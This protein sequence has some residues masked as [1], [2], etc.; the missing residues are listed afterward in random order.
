MALALGGAHVAAVLIVGPAVLASATLLAVSDRER[1]LIAATTVAWGLAGVCLVQAVPVPLPVVRLL[2]PAA[3]E[4]WSQSLRPIHESVRWA[5]LSLDPGASLLEAYKWSM[6]G[7][8]AAAS[9][10]VASRYGARAVAALIFASALLVAVLT[11]GH[12]LIDARSVFGLYDPR[13]TAVRWRVGPILNPNNLAGYLNLGA[14]AGFGLAF[15]SQQQSRRWAVLVG[16]ALL[17]GTS[18]LSGSRA[19]VVSVA[20]GVLSFLGLHHFRSEPRHARSGGS[21]TALLLFALA[22]PAGLALGWIGARQSTWQGLFDQELTKLTMIGRSLRLVADFPVFGIGRGAFESV[23]PAYGVAAAGHRVAAQPENFL[24]QWAI[25]WGLPVALVLVLLGVRS[26]RHGI[27]SASS[28]AVARALLA[29]LGA[30]FAQNLLDMGLEI[31]AVGLAVAC[32]IGA[33]SAPHG[34]RAPVDVVAAAPLQPSV[35]FRLAIWPWATALSVLV[36]L[37]SIVVS[38]W[39]VADERLALQ[40]S[41]SARSGWDEQGHASMVEQLR[42]AMRRHPAE[43]YFSHLGAAASLEAR[44]GDPMPWLSH[45]IERNPYAGR[46]RV[47]AARALVRRSA[48]SQAMSQLRSA[49]ELEPGLAGLAGSLAA[50][51]TADL[52]LLTG[53][54]PRDTSGAAFLVSAARFKIH[55]G[56]VLL[57]ERCLDA[58]LERDPRYAPALLERA[59]QVLRRVEEGGCAPRAECLSRAVLDAERLRR[60][61]PSSLEPT[62]LMAEIKKLDQ[63]L[64]T[65]FELLSVACP[66]FGADTKLRCWREAMRLV[67]GASGF[68]TELLRA[69]KAVL[70]SCGEAAARCSNVFAEVGDAMAAVEAWGA[71]LGAY[72]RAV[73]EQPTMNA[74]LGVAKTARAIGQY[75]RAQRALHQASQLTEDPGLTSRIRAELEANRRGILE[76]RVGHP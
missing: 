49:V 60:V 1:P 37:G 67:S 55:R 11:L 52:G 2:S 44:R 19:G 9:A 72:E 22:L 48:L 39:P 57:A 4:V 21:R 32:A 16:V 41:F 50:G 53:A 69:G 8:A 20:V 35:P 65:G 29:G 14:F 13:F 62:L 51:W 40:S 30:L 31:A 15:R 43:F 56:D 76:G 33:L 45:A 61:E 7:F 23:S 66:S 46:T 70:V 28:S 59:R 24:A 74:L 36:W 18:V 54:A 58:A 68:E 34:A 5:S 75:D 73:D 17:V 12:G 63:Q 71:A 42:G 10:R 38:R 6:Y 3:A 26:V 64:R 27:R 25:E 47:L